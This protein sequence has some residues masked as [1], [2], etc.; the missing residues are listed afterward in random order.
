MN[1]YK[2]ITIANNPCDDGL[3]KFLSALENR[4]SMT[5]DEGIKIVGLEEAFWYVL[6]SA[7]E[8]ILECHAKSN[9]QSVES[10]SEM[11]KDTFESGINISDVLPFFRF[12]H[13]LKNQIISKDTRL[14]QQLVPEL[15]KY[16]G[17]STI[18]KWLYSL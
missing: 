7:P 12:A 11:V 18:K 6:Q 14:A 9:N 15:I 8:K 1:V 2:N 3:S 5:M 16:H 4:E 17:E 13:S 10:M